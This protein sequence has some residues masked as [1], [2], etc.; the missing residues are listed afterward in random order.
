MANQEHA[1]YV[2]EPEGVVPPPR[3]LLWLVVGLFLLI[4]VGGIGVVLFMNNR[5][6][7][8][9]LFDLGVKLVVVVTIAIVIGL[10]VLR[11]RLPR[12]VF[13]AAIIVLLAAWLVGGTAF[14]VVYRNT[15]APGQR[16]ATKVILPFMKLFDPPLPPP[17]T[18]LPTPNPDAEG[19]I[20]PMDLLNAPLGIET[21]VPT[22]VLPAAIQVEASATPSPTPQATL[23]PTNT[24]SESTEAPEFAD[25]SSQSQSVS[26]N[27]QSALP[28]AARLYGFTVV[29]QTWNNCGP[30]NITMA[31]SYYGWTQGQEVAQAYLRPD[32][33]DKNVSPNEI[34]S[35]VNEETGVRALTRI[36]GTMDLLKG[37]PGEQFPGS[38]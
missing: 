15:L 27:P 30:A 19:G 18:S 37:L 6:A 2:R 9:T 25:A 31:L 13:L 28:G 33:E 4:V 1:N 3:F 32:K 36:G 20:S 35:F 24:P 7:L 12:R 11:T 22:T 10:V 34:V 26:A 8:V 5:P 38:D 17:D 23:T 29:K 21:P 14:I 16:E